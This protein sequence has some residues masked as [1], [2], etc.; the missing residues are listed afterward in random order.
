M[1]KY[2][3][4]KFSTPYNILKLKQNQIKTLLKD[5]RYRTFYDMQ[6]VTGI[7]CNAC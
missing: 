2:G 7:L 1:K 4:L 3:L 6:E 5:S